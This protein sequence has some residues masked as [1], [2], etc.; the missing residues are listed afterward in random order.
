MGRLYH[1]INLPRTTK[2]NHMFHGEKTE[3]SPCQPR[4]AGIFEIFLIF[5]KFH[6]ESLT[7]Q[8]LHLAVRDEGCNVVPRDYS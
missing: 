6:P 7:V 3:F 5:K 8:S 4:L 1:T 2:Q